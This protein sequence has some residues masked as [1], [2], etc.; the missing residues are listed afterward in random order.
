MTMRRL[1]FLVVLYLLIFL[2]TGCS[3]SDKEGKR[4]QMETSIIMAARSEAEAMLLRI[5]TRQLVYK[6]ENGVFL[7]CRPS[8]PDGG[9]DAIPDIWVDAGGFEKIFFRPGGTVSHQYSVTVSEDG[10]SCKLTAVSDL[11]KNGIQAVYTMT[12]SDTKP[13][14]TPEDEY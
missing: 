10:Q 9:T 11:D 13:V 4:T 3:K 1:L 2:L 5:R 12:D 14:K 6:A 8:P 7:E